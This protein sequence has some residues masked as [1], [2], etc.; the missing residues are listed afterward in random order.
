M[1]HC[2]VWHS[3]RIVE[4][5][6]AD[7]SRLAVVYALL[8]TDSVLLK[9]EFTGFKTW[10]DTL[11]GGDFGLLDYI[12]FESFDAGSKGDDDHMRRKEFS[13]LMFIAQLNY[14][15]V[16]RGSAVSFLLCGWCVC[17][18]MYVTNTDRGGF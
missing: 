12:C 18:C 15:G 2:I 17:V 11:E 16:E 5:S 1:V 3:M 9:L 7:N 6:P 10:K 8:A 13:E 14:S 4:G